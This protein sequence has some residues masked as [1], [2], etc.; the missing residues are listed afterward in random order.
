[1]S[2]CCVCVCSRCCI[3][4]LSKWPVCVQQGTSHAAS[5]SVEHSIASSPSKSQPPR[6]AFG[7]C[8][9]LAGQGSITLSMNASSELLRI[10]RLVTQGKGD[11]L[12][13]STAQE[14]LKQYQQNIRAQT[15]RCLAQASLLC[16]LPQQVCC[17][18]RG[19]L[20]P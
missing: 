1:M 10:G 13:T 2:L 11:K 20:S 7:L 18:A 19:V 3:L 4:L 14:L 12:T 17:N 15:Q 16:Q 6:P 8:Y 5:P 9:R